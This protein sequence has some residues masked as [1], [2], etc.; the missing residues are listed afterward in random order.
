MISGILAGGIPGFRI[1][2]CCFLHPA[3]AHGVFVVF[4]VVVLFYGPANMTQKLSS[5]CAEMI[6][7]YHLLPQRIF[8]TH[9]W[10]LSRYCFV[11]VWLF[12]F[13][14]GLLLFVFAFGVVFAFVFGFWLLFSGNVTRE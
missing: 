14:C 11:V 10:N 12:V 2:L 13:L 9:N 3:V 6:L 8:F 1:E 7:S 5:A 4:P